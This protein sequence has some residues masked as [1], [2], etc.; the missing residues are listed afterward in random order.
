MREIEFR[1]WHPQAKD[2]FYFGLG[3]NNFD[4]YS[5]ED[6]AVYTARIEDEYPI[7]QFTG[8]RDKNG[9]EIYEGD[10]IQYRHFD[11]PYRDI[12]CEVFFDIGSFTIKSASLDWYPDLY[13]VNKICKIIGNIYE[14]PELLK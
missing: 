7:M 8:L 11:M 9:V 4:C 10:I 12:V 1:M 6:G 2:M 3:E 5:L 14:N 13:R